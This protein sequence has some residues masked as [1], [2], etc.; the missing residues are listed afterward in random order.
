MTY[1]LIAVSLLLAACGDDGGAGPLDSSVPIDSPAA[2]TVMEVSCTG[3]TANAMVTTSESTSSYSPMATTITVGQ[4]V[5]FTTSFT[6]DVKPNSLSH[7]DPGLLV[8]FNKTACLKFTA[9]GVFN[10]LCSNHGFVGT[11]TVN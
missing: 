6:H 8:G 3:I 10:F 9:A 11:I 4:V 5:K 2:A 7:S 1:R